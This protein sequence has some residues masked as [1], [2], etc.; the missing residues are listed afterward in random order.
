MINAPD[1]VAGGGVT[2]D[3]RCTLYYCF[4]FLLL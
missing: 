3:L 1:G 4:S 2:P